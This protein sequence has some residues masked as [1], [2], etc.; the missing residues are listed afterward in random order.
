MVM[1]EIG[2]H[3]P[4]SFGLC[5]LY[6]LFISV[7]KLTE[8]LVD[9]EVLLDDRVMAIG[10]GL[11]YSY[12]YGFLKII[13]PATENSQSNFKNERFSCEMNLVIYQVVSFKKSGI[14]DRASHFEF[15]EKIQLASKKM[16]ILIPDS[17]FCTPS[18]Q[19]MAPCG[20]IERV[21]VN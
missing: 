17:C 19:D 8:N 5:G 15:E 3:W 10:H 13:L 18:F 12:Y 16:I 7:V 6:L 9:C 1:V 14:R 2:S 21:K 11:A 20:Q 4:T